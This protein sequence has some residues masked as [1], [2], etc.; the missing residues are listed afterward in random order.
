MGVIL[1]YTLG[2]FIK[3]ETK[4]NK[5]LYAKNKIV[6]RDECSK[7]LKIMGQ[8]FYYLSHFVW[9]DTEKP[10]MKRWTKVG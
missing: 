2:K 6:A 3:N 7:V 4:F 1:F 9:T 8:K 5:R 10:E